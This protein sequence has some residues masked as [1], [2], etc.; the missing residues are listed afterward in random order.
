MKTIIP[1]RELK[2]AYTFNLSSKHRKILEEV[3][4]REGISMSQ[5]LEFALEKV[6]ALYE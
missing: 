5:V 2:K 6:V 1:K 4:R 3:A